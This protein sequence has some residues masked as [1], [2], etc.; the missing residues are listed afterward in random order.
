MLTWFS[1]YTAVSKL[2]TPNDYKSYIRPILTTLTK[3]NLLND[4]VDDITDEWF[5]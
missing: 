5:I 4:E 3:I 1:F 2:T